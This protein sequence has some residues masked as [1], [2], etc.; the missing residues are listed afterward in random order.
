MSSLLYVAHVTNK[1]GRLQNQALVAAN[2]IMNVFKRGDAAGV[3]AARKKAEEVFGIGWQA[4][5]A[6]IYK[7]GPQKS[8]IWGIGQ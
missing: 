7:E 3:A 4:K 1:Q 8:N 2:E 6:D 5:G